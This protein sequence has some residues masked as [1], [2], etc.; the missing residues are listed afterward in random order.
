[1]TLKFSD[2]DDSEEDF[3]EGDK[4]KESLDESEE[5]HI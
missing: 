5:A 2:V 3:E 4:E 1:M